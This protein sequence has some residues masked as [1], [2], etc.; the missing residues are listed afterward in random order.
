MATETAPAPAQE[1]TTPAPV[2][3]ATATAPAPS[4]TPKPSD[5]QAPVA[6]APTESAEDKA[7]KLFA[8]IAE[9]KA[10]IRRTE[11]S[12][13]EREAKIK[14]WEELEAK[15]GDDPAVLLERYPD[16][17]ERLTKRVLELSSEQD[18]PPTEAD[19][20]AA[21][22]AELNER[23]KAEADAK[24]AE[25][26]AAEDKGIESGLEA[27]RAQLTGEK[28]ELINA[29][30]AHDRVLEGMTAYCDEHK[31]TPDGEQLI[32]LRDAVADALE[33]QLEDEAVRELETL[34]RKVP[35]LSKRF[36]TPPAPAAENDAPGKQDSP[37]A[38]GSGSVTLT[39]RNTSEAPP[40]RPVRA[41]SRDESI[42]AAWEAAK[43][44]TSGRRAAL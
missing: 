9:K 27:L 29:R 19:R 44:A 33:K 17:Y 15:L 5:G 16:L 41:L 11:K 34:Q 24:A 10:E 36:A 38:N 8:K 22:E 35:K 12:L 32:A 6:A 37:G 42:D 43:A 7:S 18:E 21:I 20:L 2:E 4:D 25:K 30:S 40:P 3:T 39:S 13:G 26:K 1:G 28:Y 23:K 14:H 31:F